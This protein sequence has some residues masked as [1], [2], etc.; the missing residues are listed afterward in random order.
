VSLSLAA[1]RA[2]TLVVRDMILANEGGALWLLDGPM[3][4]NPGEA[5]SG[6]PLA[7]IALDTVSLTLHETL[8]VMLLNVVG[9]AAS[10]GQPTW[11]RFVDGDGIGVYDVTAGPPGSGAQAIVSNVDIP[12]SAQIW[13]GGELT[14]D[15]SFAE[16]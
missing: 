15:G 8:A 10:S 14:V 6:A 1:R 5:P 3:A 7:I 13:T 9:Y 2:R 16:P 11:G 12:A 4:N